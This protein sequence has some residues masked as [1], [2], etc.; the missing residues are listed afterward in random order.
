MRQIFK[1]SY[2]RRIPQTKCGFHGTW[3]DSI[4]TCS[5]SNFPQG[6][7]SPIYTDVFIEVTEEAY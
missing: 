1:E 2:E 6:S 3:P 5:G 7:T 4:D